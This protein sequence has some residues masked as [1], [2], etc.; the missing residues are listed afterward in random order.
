MSSELRY[1]TKCMQIFKAKIKPFI[2]YIKFKLSFKYNQLSKISNVIN[3][4]NGIIMSKHFDQNI[5]F[6]VKLTEST[7]QEIT[8]HFPTIIIK[9]LD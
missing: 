3:S 7:F 9:R 2:E 8:K 6:Q 5:T 4:N 1:L